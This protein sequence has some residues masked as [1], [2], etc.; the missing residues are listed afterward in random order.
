MK[1]KQY[2]KYKESNV[3]FLSK[4]PV[5]W[6]VY[7]LKFLISAL[8]SGK[9]E[10][11]EETPF[12]NGAF[13]LGGEH[14]N[15]DGTLKLDNVRLVSEEFYNSMNQGK[16]RIDDTLLVKDGATIGKTALI[17]KKEYDKMCVNEHVFILRPNK[18]INPKLLYYLIY[19]D[20]GFTQ[21]KLTETGSA[22]G[23]VNSEF[24]SKVTFTISGDSNEQKNI[25]TFLD[26][27]TTEINSLL[28]KDK[29]LIELLKE[30]R[31]ALINHV[32]TKGLNPKTKFYD[33]GIDWIGKIPEDWEVSKLKFI[34][35]LIVDGTHFTP[36]YLAEGVPF[37]R[38]TD[39]QTDKID[40]NEIKFISEKES[41]EINGRCNPKKGD[42]LFSKNGTIGIPKVVDWDFPFSIFVSLCLIRPN[43][44]INI[45][46][47][48]YFLLSKSIIEQ[49]HYRSKTTSVTNLHLDQIKEFILSY[50]PKTEQT[51]IVS[52]LDKATSKIDE[53]V[54]KI[55]KRI[56]LL[57]EYKKSLIHNVVTGKVNVRSKE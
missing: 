7:R 34:T 40:F 10:P 6:N 8:E 55:E 5:E 15:W 26:K 44:K 54:K 16:I 28:E 20:C 13:S 1:F 47:L 42:L 31:I 43:K 51:Q 53:A 41:K 30:R 21:I 23:G 35:E 4:V 29:H 17:L 49:I 12:E 48:K 9:R 3:D 57:E 18:K 37:L 25:T 24:I 19:S 39:I 50:P 33:S 22:Q 36:E 11:E 38:V 27:K 45:N 14:V 56:E 52:Y 2:Q 32:V 46:Y